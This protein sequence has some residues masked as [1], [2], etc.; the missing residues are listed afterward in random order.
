MYLEATC[1]LHLLSTTCLL[2][3]QQL[4]PLQAADLDMLHSGEV[5]YSMQTTSITA[6]LAY[7]LPVLS[8]SF[9]VAANV[10]CVVGATHVLSS[11]GCVVGIDPRSCS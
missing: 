9:K 7:T 4:L 10:L 6:H 1:L 11:L 2:G 8:W 3:S 5:Q